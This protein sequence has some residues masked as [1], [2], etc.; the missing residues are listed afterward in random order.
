[1]GRYIPPPSFGTPV[2]VTSESD[3]D[4][5]VTDKDAATATPP[6]KRKKRL[7]RYKDSYAQEYAWV[8]K[9]RKDQFH[10]YCR[11]CTKDISI[12][13]GRLSDLKSHLTTRVHKSN[14]E[15]CKTN[16]CLVLFMYLR[17]TTIW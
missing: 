6:K 3:K 4:N 5:A 2:T 10:A 17:K 13:C 1:M 15:A 7:Q 11:Y 8:T 16:K 9:S 12:G 14:A